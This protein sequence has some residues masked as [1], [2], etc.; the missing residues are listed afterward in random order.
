MLIDK[1]RH[2]ASVCLQYLKEHYEKH[3]TI[4]DIT[5]KSVVF[6]D[7][8]TVNIGRFLESVRINHRKFLSSSSK[9]GF[10]DEVMLL[11]YKALDDMGFIWEPNLKKSSMKRDLYIDYLREHYREYGT[12]N[13]ITSNFVV[14]YQ[15]FELKVGEFLRRTA[16]SYKNV[17]YISSSDLFFKRCSKLQEMGFDFL[18]KSPKTIRDIALDNDVGLEDLKKLMTR[19]AGNMDKALK[20]TLANKRSKERGY[21][22]ENF[23]VGQFLDEFSLDIDSLKKYL[24]DT[25]VVIGDGDNAYSDDMLLR[26]F[27]TKN[28]YD[29]DLVSL[30]IKIKREGLDSNDLL[31]ASYTNCVYGKMTLL[32]SILEYASIS[33]RSVVDEMKNNGILVDQALINVCFRKKAGRNFD[34]LRGVFYDYL[35]TYNNLFKTGNTNPCSGEMEVFIDEIASYYGLDSS[36]RKILDETFI[37]YNSVIHRVHLADVAFEGDEV[38]RGI[39]IMNYQ[40]DEDDMEQAFLLPLEFNQYKLL[41]EYRRIYNR[42]KTLSTLIPDFRYMNDDRKRLTVEKYRLSLEELFYIDSLSNKQ[43]TNAMDTKHLTYK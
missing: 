17:S 38:K 5:Y 37:Y 35:K 2:R 24:K 21:I 16:A 41:G 31:L 28:G 7:G 12:I 8:E 36:E 10:N 20:I 1:K 3:G 27:C 32:K 39:K 13:D 18:R 34:Y 43:Q 15:G 40:L 25:T 14:T 30:M 33:P 19:F 6:I 11:N 9:G 29:Y 23:T 22:A 26:D 42:K 4:N